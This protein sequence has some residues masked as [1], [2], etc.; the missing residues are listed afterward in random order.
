[1]TIQ[2]TVL[3]VVP[4]I[5]LVILIVVMVRVAKDHPERLETLR[6]WGIVAGGLAVII[7][8]VDFFAKRH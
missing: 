2:Q 1:M 6:T 3:A 5:V 8:L 7:Q 4:L